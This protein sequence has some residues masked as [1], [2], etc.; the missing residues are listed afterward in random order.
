MKFTLSWLKEVEALGMQ[1]MFARDVGISTH[2]N[3][4]MLLQMNLVSRLS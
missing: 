4:N 2:Y 1:D 3:F